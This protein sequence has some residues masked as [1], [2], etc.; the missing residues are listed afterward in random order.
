MGHDGVPI[1]PPHQKVSSPCQGRLRFDPVAPAGGVS[2][3]ERVGWSDAAELTIEMA[4]VETYGRLSSTTL[5]SC[6][7]DRRKRPPTLA[8][9]HSVGEI[10]ELQEGL[11]A[12]DEISQRAR[13]DLGSLDELP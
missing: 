3:D 10:Q 1:V 7:A 2:A 5:V 6:S 8:I 11:G 13:K 12:R 4:T 9:E